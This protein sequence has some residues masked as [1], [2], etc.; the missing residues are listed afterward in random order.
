MDANAADELFEGAR[1]ART[2]F[3]AARDSGASTIRNPARKGEGPRMRPRGDCRYEIQSDAIFWSEGVAKAFGQA[4]GFAPANRQ[5]YLDLVHPEDREAAAARVGEAIEK[6]VGFDA[7]ERVLYPDGRVATV[8]CVVHVE[9]SSQGHPVALVGTSELIRIELHSEPDA[10]PTMPS[11]RPS[12]APVTRPPGAET[13]STSWAS[14]RRTRAEIGHDLNNLVQALQFDVDLSDAGDTAALSASNLRRVI[15]SAR[16]LGAEL[17]DP[18]KLLTPEVELTD[19]ASWLKSFRARLEFF[20]GDEIQFTLRVPDL[21]L[22]SGINRIRLEQA[23]MNLVTNAREASGGGGRIELRLEPAGHGRLLL[24]LRDEGAGIDPSGLHRVWD[25][26]ESTRGP[27][28]GQGL[29]LA[30]KDI[31]SMGGII[32]IESELGRG[33]RVRIHLPRERVWVLNPRR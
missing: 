11:S 7:L 10:A 19:L 24:E 32:E 1:P 21:P 30:R 28:R 2:Q 17:L 15:A 22:Y 6:S 9:V 23:L 27:G 20:A 14:P 13:S 29:G 3:H 4:P 8:R 31:E 18:S 33:T 25:R 12:G 5:Q 26:G 16:E